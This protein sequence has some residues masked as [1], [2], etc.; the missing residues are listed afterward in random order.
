MSDPVSS[1]YDVP[2]ETRKSQRERDRE[3]E[4]ETET[5]TERRQRWFER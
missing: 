2:P 1:V 3:T 4:T 5:K